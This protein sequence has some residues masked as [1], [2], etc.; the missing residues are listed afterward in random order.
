MFDLISFTL[1]AAVANNGTVTVG[2]P[3]GRSQGHYD[4]TPGKHKL[5]VGSNDYSAPADFTLTFNANASD[6]TL[7]NKSGGAWPSGSVCTLQVDRPGVNGREPVIPADSD[8]VR[9]V[10]AGVYLLNLGSP[11]TADADG[12]CASQDLTAAGVASVDTT[13][14]GAIA[15]AALAGVADVPRNVVAAWTGAAVL[16][17]TGEDEQGEVIVESSASGTSF[18]GKK[19]FKRVTDFSV[20]ANVTGL[21]IGTGD[22]LGLPVAVGKVGQ[23]L[24]EFKDGVKL[25]QRGGMVYLQGLALEA[26][27]DAG[28]GLNFVSPVAGRISKVLT[29]AQGTITT[30]GAVTCEVNTTAVDGL[31]VTVADGTAE[32][33]VD[34]DTPTAGH[35]SA[36]VAVGDRI[37]LQF[38]AGF[39]ASADLMCI[40]EIEADHATQGTFV[41]AVGSEA[42]ATTGDVRGTYD[43][44]DA[45]DG[46]D[47]YMLLVSLPNAD[48]VGVAQ[49]GG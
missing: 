5:V 1:A 12:Y 13:A 31:S 43:P 42:T 30:G 38:A 28:T 24:A 16:T 17:V 27:V 41:A 49:Y 19:A 48:D 3:D 4:W 6:I 20:S 47:G 32:G 40:I 22:V 18:T 46:D 26:A 37:E 14:E 33:E 35:A 34:S 9:Q 15:A 36:R 25:A 39:N 44:Y 2:Y 11:D 45:C 7:T 21:T 29:I 23:I 8:R 10:E